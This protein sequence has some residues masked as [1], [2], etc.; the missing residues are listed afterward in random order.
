MREAAAAHVVA[1]AAAAAPAAAV[2][3]R[4]PFEPLPR[5]STGSRPTEAGPTGAGE[6]NDS[7]TS[8]SHA[9]AEYA[10]HEDYELASYL[11]AGY[12]GRAAGD[13][14]LIEFGGEFGGEFGAGD[15]T[16]GQLR[17]LYASA[18]RLGAEP[19]GLG[20]AEEQFGQ[21]LERQRKLISE[22]FKESGALSDGMPRMPEMPDLRSAR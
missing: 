4:S 19:I 22:Y 12:E 2:P 17:S 5:A 14:D 6:T 10:E 3:I 13:S 15:G 11:S 18:E 9:A 21:L 7:E 1:D 16:L 20:G 8:D